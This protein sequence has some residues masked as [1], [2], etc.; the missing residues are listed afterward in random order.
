MSKFVIECPKCG[1][2]VEAKKG[3]WIFGRKHIDCSCGYEI[4][5]QTDKMASRTCPHCGNTV[6]FDQ[7][8]GAKARCP[9]CHEPINTL[10]EQDKTVEFSCAQCGIRLRT[11]KGESLFTCPV[12]DFENNIAERV[13]KEKLQRESLPSVIKYEG[14]NSTFI[15]KHPIEDFC[16][17]S[18]L[19]VHESQ[20]AVFF[21]DGQALD[22][23]GPGRHTLETQRLPMLEKV[24]KLPTNN[25]GTFHSEIYYINK[26]VQMA[27][28]WGT[29]DKVRFIDPLT[30]APLEL[31]AS[32]EMN[33]EVQDGRKLLLKLVGT[34]RGIAWGDGPEF[35]KSLQASFRPLIT[36]A[37][38]T[39][40]SAVIKKEQIDILDI[41]DKLDIVSASLRSKIMAGFEEYGLTIPQF[42]VTNILLPPDNDPNF[43]LI[44]KLHT[45]LLQSK[46]YQAEA[47]IK[48][49]QAQTEAQYRTAQEQSKAEIEVAHREVE[50]QKERTETEKARYQAER[51]I[52]EAQA[53]AQG[54]R[55]TGLAE[56]EVMHAQGY[57]KRDILHAEVQKA[58]AEGIGNMGPSISTG[59]G[60]GGIV[61]D[62]VGLGVGM[63]AASAI[64]P[65]LGN[66]FQGIN[67]DT[68]NQ[69]S[70]VQTSVDD[71]SSII[72][73][74][75]WNCPA[76]GAKSISSK[77]CPD[78]GAKKPIPIEPWDCPTCGAKGITSKFC[79]DCGTKK[80]IYID[81]WTC[82]TCNTKEI[83][84]R[85]CPECGTK[86]PAETEG[87]TCPDCG[88][89]DISTSFC[90]ECGRKR[91]D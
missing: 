77:F 11:S 28:K 60:G 71:T 67:T 76:C 7:T 30:S 17:G 27:I 41:D 4:N 69:Q 1:K 22:M 23:F 63:A 51:R 31:G 12:C 16:Y 84:S 90:P 83:T 26:T 59:G 79:P 46:A 24:Y 35:S 74:Q 61:G 75:T 25:E 37:V 33:L 91:G 15:W 49:V 40:L 86:R 85:F 44:R 81:A 89:K 2:Y 5:I 45:V 78:C 8:K 3:F 32:G 6:V 88:T 38:K 68:P 10:E 82:P 55:L 58:Y 48:T 56:A 73:A 52:I 36:N 19:I 80:P 39:N 29:P 57:N 21:R 87:W 13:Q 66:M 42:Y 9:V 18:Q 70:P 34:M 53:K 14:D 47:A 62:M 20:E 54:Q 64:A 43:I 50:M 72:L 65:Q